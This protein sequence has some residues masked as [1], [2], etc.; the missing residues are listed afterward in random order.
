MYS[1]SPYDRFGNTYDVAR[2]L[3]PDRS[4]NTT[5]YD[6]YSPLY[7]PGAYAITY[8]VAFTLSSAVLVH[9]VLY[10]GP[11]LVNAAKNVKIEKDDIHA[12]LMRSYPEVPN[13]WYALL[14]V[15]MAAL[16]IVTNEVRT[17]S[18]ITLNDVLTSGTLGL[19][20]RVTSMGH[21]SVDLYSCGIYA[22]LRLYLCHSR[23]AGQSF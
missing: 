20:Y 21:G 7:L 18:V 9:T 13:W 1:N 15:L 10:W 14:F 11:A 23:S 12:K 4:L 16:T 8:L 6:E 17:D 22:A 19:A 3:N 2:V 5:A